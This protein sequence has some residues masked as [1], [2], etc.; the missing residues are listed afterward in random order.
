[1]TMG[2]FGVAKN[3]T[4]RVLE[5]RLL[6]FPTCLSANTDRQSGFLMPAVSYSN[7]AASSTSNRILAID[8]LPT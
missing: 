6:Y 3:A 7:G 2:G 8:K 1:V 4:F 5:R